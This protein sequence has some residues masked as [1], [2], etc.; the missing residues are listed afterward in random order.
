MRSRWIAKIVGQSIYAPSS[1]LV[2]CQP[3]LSEQ[4]NEEKYT[5]LPLCLIREKYEHLPNGPEFIANLQ[6]SLELRLW[7]K[8]H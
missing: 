8:T 4:K 3:R 1:C 6:K 5:E 7:L 2:V